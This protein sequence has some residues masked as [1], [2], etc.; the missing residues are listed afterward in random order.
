MPA[1]PQRIVLVPS[2]NGQGNFEWKLKHNNGPESGPGN[3]PKVVLPKDSG[4]AEFTVSIAGNPAN[5]KFAANP[6]WVA[7][8]STSP[9]EAGVDNQICGVKILPNGDLKFIDMNG[10]APLQLGYRLKFDGAPDLDPIIDN[11]GGGYAPPAPPGGLWGGGGVST[12]LLLGAILISLILG[13]LVGR[14]TKSGT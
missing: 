10:G 2:Q 7:Q 5:I 6:L 11:G 9:T 1:T 4:P 14:M 3:Y 8:G 13:A 12:A